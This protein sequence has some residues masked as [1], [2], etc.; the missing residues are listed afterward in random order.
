MADAKTA[1]EKISPDETTSERITSEAKHHW[2]W[3]GPATSAYL[4][5]ITSWMADQVHVPSPESNRPKHAD[6][7]PTWQIQLFPDAT[8]RTFQK[9]L[10]KLRADAFV[11]A[12]GEAGIAQVITSI[13]SAKLA[14][15]QAARISTGLV[16]PAERMHL[17]EV[18][19][20][21]HVQHPHQIKDVLDRLQ[22]DHLAQP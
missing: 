5:G 9:T 4:D 1:T 2:C 21:L 13:A 18:G 12:I 6:S 3:I 10:G 17:M 16:S 8:P 20:Q 22:R 19:V 14:H 15:P 11:W 7:I